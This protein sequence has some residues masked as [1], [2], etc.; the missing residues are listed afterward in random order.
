M[1]EKQAI[2]FWTIVKCILAILGV[3]VVIFSI[4]A[5]LYGLE[6]YIDSCIDQAINND[7]FIKKVASHIRPFIIFDAKG[8]IHA[9]MGAM[10]YLE[11][12]EVDTEYSLGFKIIITP[13]HHLIYEPVLEKLRAPQISSREMGAAA[14]QSGHLKDTTPHS[15]MQLF[16]TEI[17]K[18]L[19]NESFFE[20]K[21]L[22][23]VEQG[24]GN[25]WIYKV[26]TFFHLEE[27]TQWRFRLEILK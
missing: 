10:Q 17:F 11:R 7:R 22:I 13:K 20:R 19:V 21:Y 3:I 12:I 15:G 2:Q 23:Q 9:D 1:R 8:T 5:G 24:S 16:Q 18:A 6:K 26:Q 27:A 14:W 4:I 25:Q